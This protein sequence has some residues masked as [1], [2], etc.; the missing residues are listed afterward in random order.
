MQTLIKSDEIYINDMVDIRIVK[1]ERVLPIKEQPEVLRPPHS[2]NR[3]DL[4]EEECKV[5][6]FKAELIIYKVCEF[7]GLNRVEVINNI[8]NH[9][10]HIIKA[11]HQSISLIYTNTELCERII[12][13]LFGVDHSTINYAKKR[14]K[15]DMLYLSRKLEFD[16]LKEKIKEL[17]LK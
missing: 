3:R 1:R 5:E 15:S 14:V 4:T 11:K 13:D 12:G 7:Y 2:Q 6:I 17:H 10:A 8:N 9:K 16:N